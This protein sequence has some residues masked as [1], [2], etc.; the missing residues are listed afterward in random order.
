MRPPVSRTDPAVRAIFDLAEHLT[1]GRKIPEDSRAM[2]L[3]ALGTCIAD[4]FETS[5]FVALGLRKWGGISPV[6]KID[7]NR[8]D[9]ALCRLRRRVPEWSVLSPGAAAKAMV[10]SL[11]RYETTRWPRERDSISGPPSEPNA[12]W[13]SM[14]RGG[15]DIPGE[16]RLAQ[17]LKMEIQDS[18][19][20]RNADATLAS[21]GDDHV[22]ADQNR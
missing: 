20:F 6:R 8:R 17:I 9:R 12:A 5:L 7:L 4:G 3:D 16:R 18:F 11:A 1:S 19:E 14:L 13:W 2:L 21:E 10:A 22:Q 15:L